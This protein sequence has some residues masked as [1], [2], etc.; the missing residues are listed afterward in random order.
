MKYKAVISDLDGTLLGE[1]HKI[2][3]YTKRVIKSVIDKGVKFFIATGRHHTDVSAIKKTL[4]LDTVMITSNGARV[5][6][7]K[8][9]EIFASN[10]PQS[11]SQE[12]L[13]LKFDK[14]I[15][16][17][18]YAGDYWYL[19]EE[20]WWAKEFHSESGFT[21]SIIDFEELK[22]TDI[23][24]FFYLHEDPKVI[25]E[26][27]EF[28]KEKYGDSLQIVRSLPICLEIMNKNTTKGVAITELLKAEGIDLSETISFGDGLNDLEML[29]I[30]GKAFIMKN[31]SKTLKETLPNLEVIGSNTEDGVAKKL[32][33]IFEVGGSNESSITEG[34]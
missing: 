12:I 26:L 23:T 1:D 10:L 27:E 18:V 17:N 3:E 4:N 30:T 5:H 8:D 16:V 34:N 11:L 24:K 13:D 7:E 28:F 20:A 21:Y 19:E 6:D 33:E 15:H 32:E 14:G 29:S 25:K 22:E 9:K 31:G 2:S